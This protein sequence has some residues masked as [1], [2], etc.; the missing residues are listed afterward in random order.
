[1]LKCTYYRLRDPA[2]WLPLAA[3]VSSRNLDFNLLKSSV[4]E[5]RLR[6]SIRFNPDAPAAPPPTPTWSG[7]STAAAAASDVAI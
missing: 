3:G 2:S 4:I 1:M 5:K 7:W 6:S